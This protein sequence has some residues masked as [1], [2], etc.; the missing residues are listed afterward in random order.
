MNK[1]LHF[2]KLSLLLLHSKVEISNS[3]G[4]VIHFFLSLSF[5]RSFLITLPRKKKYL[6]AFSQVCCMPINK[7]FT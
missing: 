6:T 5:L 7:S 3:T 1:P 4:N 2:S